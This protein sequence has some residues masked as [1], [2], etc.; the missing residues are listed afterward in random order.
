MN[1]NRVV[2]LYLAMLTGHV[3]HVFE[4]TWGRFW[5]IDAFYGQ[6]WFL[7]VNWVLFCIPVA[8]LYFVLQQKRWAYRLSMIYASIMIANGLGHNF[9]T[10]VT[11]RYFGGFA[12]GFSGIALVLLGLPMIYILHKEMPQSPPE[13]SPKEQ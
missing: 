10:L 7:V 2:A 11:R 4:E 1:T 3:A 9:A 8:I 5:L 13:G 6:G 12:G